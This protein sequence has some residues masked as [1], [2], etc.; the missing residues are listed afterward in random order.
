MVNNPS[1]EKGKMMS[2]RA[3]CQY[4]YSIYPYAMEVCNAPSGRHTFD[5]GCKGHRSSCPSYESATPQHVA[6]KLEE[7]ITV[8]GQEARLTINGVVFNGT[9]NINR[10]QLAQ[11]IVALYAKEK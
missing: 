5:E 2:K 10:Q 9:W 11:A 4:Y 3:K 8:I 1:G 7:I 6:G